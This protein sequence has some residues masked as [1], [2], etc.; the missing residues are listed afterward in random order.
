MDTFYKNLLYLCKNL[1][2]MRNLL[3]VLSIFLSVFLYSQASS[4]PFSNEE[5]QAGEN[6][7]YSSANR[8]VNNYGDTR[9]NDAAVAQG[10]PNPGDPVPVDQYAGLLLF[11]AVGIIIY[12][13]HRKRKLL[14]QK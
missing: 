9:D 11:T 6:S 3:A 14:T 13:T 2:L 4:N 5:A 12:T 7:E 1:K 10:A 8:N